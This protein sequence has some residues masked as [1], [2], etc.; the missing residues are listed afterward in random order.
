MID[1]L[2]KLAGVLRE[3]GN[4]SEKKKLEEAEA[5]HREALMQSRNILG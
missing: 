1:I 3:E 4:D 5:M 2:N